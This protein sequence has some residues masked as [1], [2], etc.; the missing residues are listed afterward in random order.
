M[1]RGIYIAANGMMSQRMAQEA[2]GQN[3]T[4]LTTPGY[5]EDR[6]VLGSFPEVLLWRLGP[7]IEPVGSA[8]W[9]QRVEEIVTGF[10]QGP[11][12]QTRRELDFALQ[13]PGFFAVEGPDGIYYT[14][15]GNFFRDADG[16]LITPQGYYVQGENGRLRLGEGEVSVT[17][18]GRVSTAGVVVDRLQVVDFADR[19]VLEKVGGSLF[20]LPGAGQAVAATG[21]TVRQGYLEQANTNLAQVMSDLLISFRI[22]EAG[23]RVVQAQ[24]SLAERAINQVG[25][26]R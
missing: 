25:Q 17:E 19:G 5:Q 26:L 6:A 10:S 22:Y 2:T 1:L 16:F 15:A 21:Y 14:R 9:G 23:Q 18:E 7:G 8:S 20:R 11:L 4:N 3:L 12:E 24:D 13:G